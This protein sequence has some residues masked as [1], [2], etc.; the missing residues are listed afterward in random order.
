MIR[1]VEHPKYPPDAK[2]KLIRAK[3]N[4]VWVLK[5]N[6]ENH[7]FEISTSVRNDIGGSIPKWITKKFAGRMT[8][9]IYERLNKTRSK[10]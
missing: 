5:K 3:T 1:S 8:R 4:Q 10:L 9:G 7:N 6:E 2:S